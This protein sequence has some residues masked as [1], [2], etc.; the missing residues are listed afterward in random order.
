MVETASQ[1]IVLKFVENIFQIIVTNNGKYA[2][3]LVEIDRETK[4]KQKK[5]K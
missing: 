2:I 5:I 4:P 1:N 3:L